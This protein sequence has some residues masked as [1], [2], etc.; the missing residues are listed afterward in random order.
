MGGSKAFRE[1]S[2]AGGG[3]IKSILE[4]PLTK[5]NKPWNEMSKTE[6][7]RMVVEFVKQSWNSGS[8]VETGIFTDGKSTLVSSDD[9]RSPNNLNDSYDYESIANNEGPMRFGEEGE[10]ATTY[11]DYLN[12]PSTTS[13]G[14]TV[15][16]EIVDDIDDK[17]PLL[18]NNFTEIK[19]FLASQR[20]KK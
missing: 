20:W 1:K 5:I 8:Y 16:D 10:I 14:K 7:R 9:I 17:Y 13:S 11:T 6:K 4:N 18:M 3:S 19:R 2:G 12:S 15:L